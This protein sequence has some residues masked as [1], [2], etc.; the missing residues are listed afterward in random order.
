MRLQTAV[1]ILTLA[2]VTSGLSRAQSQRKS[3]D[4]LWARLSYSSTYGVD[5]RTTEGYPQIC[6]ALY[7]SGYYQVLRTT[8]HGPETLHGTLSRNQLLHF[9]RMLREL[10]FSVTSGGFVRQGS[11]SLTA[12]VERKGKTMRYAWVDP[13]NERPFP[14]PAMRIVDW[15]Q[16][17]T[18]QGALPLTLRELSERP[19][20]PPASTKPLQPV[21]ASLRPEALSCER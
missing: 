9:A 3:P 14:A 19:I 1:L 11:E 2:Q 5:W 13:D 4:T 16:N 10:D 17:F 12:E 6:F 21:I 7:R 15:L 8:E 20:C 18:P